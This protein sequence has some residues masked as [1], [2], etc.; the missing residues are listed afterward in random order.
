MELSKILQNLTHPVEQLESGILWY[1]ERGNR[2]ESFLNV[3]MAVPGIGF[4]A[5]KLKGWLGLLQIIIGVGVAILDQL[6][7]KRGDVTRKSLTFAFHGVCN[8]AGALF[9]PISVMHRI[10]VLFVVAVCQAKEDY[11]AV[12]I[13]YERV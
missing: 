9:A 6:G 10:C 12:L 1:Q 3:G 5:I 8:I 4:Y 2:I 13:A 7:Q 11:P